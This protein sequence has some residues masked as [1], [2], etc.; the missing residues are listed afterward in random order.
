LVTQWL[1][2]AREDLLAGESILT[3]PLSSYGTASFHAQQ[4][5]EKALKA[6]LVK[7]QTEFSKSHNIGQLLRLAEPPAPGISERLEL[8]RRRI[9]RCG[10]RTPPAPGRPAGL[11]LGREPCFVRTRISIPVE[12]KERTMNRLMMVPGLM[13]GL[14]TATAASAQPPAAQPALVIDSGET[15]WDGVY[16]DLTEITRT[17]PTELTVRF[18]Y[19]NTGT[20]ARRLPDLTNIVTLTRVFDPMGRKIYGVIKDPGG[21]PLSSSTLTD[22]NSGKS[23]TAG[24]AQAHWAKVE[25]PP[26]DV[27]TV[28]VVVPGANPFENVTVGAKPAVKPLAGPPAATATQDSEA[29]GVIVE[30]TA[31][32]RAP[33]GFLNAEFRYRNKGS[34]AFTFPHLTNQVPKAHVVDPESRRKYDVAKDQAG[35][36]LAATTLAFPA[37]GGAQLQP[38]ESIALWAKFPAPPENVKQVTLTLPL[39]PPFDNLPIAGTGTGSSG[40][41]AVAG[42]VTGLEAAVKELGATVTDAEIRINLAADVL[43][44]FDRAD[45]KAN[46]EPALQ[47]VATV[48]NAHPA[49]QV[50]IDGHTDGKGDERYNQTLSEKRAGAVA[51]WLTTRAQ[52]D[53]SRFVVRG[54][55]KTKPVAPNS[56][57]DGSDD[58]SGRAKNRRVEIVIKKQ[59]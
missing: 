32:R 51:Q 58:P 23:L 19:R 10:D 25:A 59:S 17:A 37:T 1:A 16:C 41:V 45:I 34:A 38:N 43:F 20:K 54:L 40:G 14:M 3:A 24:S 4:A 55:G 8:A 13:A 12:T 2:L 56:K 15:R 48:L 11:T 50:T 5:A 42:A 33:G 27:T 9:R 39:A 47:K 30:V 21:K 22:I 52:V 6:L 28:T 46:A 49:A 57:M 36:H 35:N 53:G 29:E 7:H 18:R 26:A 31:L 44:D